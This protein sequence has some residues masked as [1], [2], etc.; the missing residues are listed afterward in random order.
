MCFVNNYNTSPV[1][2]PFG[3]Y[4]KS[5]EDPG[6]RAPQTATLGAPC[7]SA[8]APPLP[9]PSAAISGRGGGT[10]R[11]L[12][13]L[14]WRPGAPGV[15]GAWLRLTWR[16]GSRLGAWSRGPRRA[17]LRHGGV[18]APGRPGPQGSPGL[19]H[20]ASSVLRRFGTEDRARSGQ[21]PLCT[22]PLH[23]APGDVHFGDRASPL[24]DRAHPSP[25][26][27]DKGCCHLAWSLVPRQ[28]GRVPASEEA[29]RPDRPRARPGGADGPSV[30]AGS[31]P[32]TEPSV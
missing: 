18:L 3:G 25:G 11:L 29:E 14:S 6:P 26:W 8:H 10:P 31:E 5:G 4:K 12:R 19:T 7:G 2:L 17:C 9:G 22:S 1:E 28:L 27:G 16:G 32:P 15:R 30:R 24:G 23:G 21:R 13:L 20:P